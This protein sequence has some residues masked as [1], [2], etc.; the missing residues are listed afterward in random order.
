MELFI[1]Q[2]TLKKVKIVTKEKLKCPHCGRDIAYPIFRFNSTME[3]TKCKHKIYV[4]TKT[5]L[6]MVLLIFFI[7]VSDYIIDFM[8]QILPNMPSL[9]YY[10]LLFIFV[11][12]AL[13]AMMFIMIKTLGY[14]SIYRIRD[15]NYYKDTIKNAE[16]RREEKKKGKKK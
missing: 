11:M 8:K 14:T 2:G 13:F 1:G 16:D 3:C 12:L 5:T 10:V 15:D 9:V 7:L 6:Y 4:E